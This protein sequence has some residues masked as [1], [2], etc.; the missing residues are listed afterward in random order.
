VFPGEAHQFGHWRDRQV[1]G[2]KADG[3]AEPEQKWDDP[4]FVA[5]VQNKGGYPPPDAISGF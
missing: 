4:V 1:E 3:D 5:M 2:D